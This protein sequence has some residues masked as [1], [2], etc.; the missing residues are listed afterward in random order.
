MI[1]RKIVINSSEALLVCRVMIMGVWE[2]ASCIYREGW[3]FQYPIAMHNTW[4]LGVQKDKGGGV[5]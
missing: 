5:S 2:L 3:R 1:E 4:G